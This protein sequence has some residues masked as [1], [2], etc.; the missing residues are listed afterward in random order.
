MDTFKPI[1]W[2][3]GPWSIALYGTLYRHGWFGKLE[4]SHWIDNGFVKLAATM[5]GM[6][7][8]QVSKFHWYECRFIVHEV[9]IYKTLLLAIR[10]F[11]RCWTNVWPEPLS[12]SVPQMW[13]IYLVDIDRPWMEL[14]LDM[15]TTLVKHLARGWNRLT[16]PFFLLLPEWAC[17]LNI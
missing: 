5:G 12:S 9:V 15:M 7:P 4:S 10:P 1:L 3:P 13:N 8:F 2:I 16:I 6:H 17:D 11:I 14:C